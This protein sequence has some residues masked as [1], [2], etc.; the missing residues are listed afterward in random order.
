M[1]EVVIKETLKWLPEWTEAR[2]LWL[3]WPYRADIFSDH[4]QAAQ[5]DLLVLLDRLQGLAL[6][7]QL[8][9]PS[10]ERSKAEQAIAAAGLQPVT[11]HEV[12]YGDV[13]LRDCAPFV[14]ADGV[15]RHFAFDSW[16]G[17]DDQ[18][19]LDIM[20][21]DWLS[22]TLKAKTESYTAVLEGGAIYTDGEGTGLACTGS[23]IYRAGN[24]DWSQ[25]AFE[26]TLAKALGIEKVLWLPGKLSADETGGH[27]DNMACFLAPGRIALNMPASPTHPDYATCRRVLTFLE[28]AKDAQGRS[29]EIVRMPLPPMPRLTAQEAATITTRQ[30]IR[31]RIAGMPLM[32]SYLNFIRAGNIVVLPEFGIA[33]DDEA[34]KVL[35]KALP[36][37]TIIRA[38]TRGLLVGGGGWHCASW[39]E[40]ELGNGGG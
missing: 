9:V 38:P 16:G 28:R 6:S 23:T 37:C 34:Y 10:A 40:P 8:M 14:G 25:A 21:R 18:W 36:D 2:A 33:E 24:E 22:R 39:V 26:D 31:R 11:L 20:A 29:F 5:S 17:I 1:S 27:V 12:D 35:A 19:P 7:V 4:G 13:W 15:H 32:A 3:R 30:G